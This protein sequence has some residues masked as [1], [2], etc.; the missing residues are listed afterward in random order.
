MQVIGCDW[1]SANWQPCWSGCFRMRKLGWQH[2]AV[3]TVLRGWG[4]CSRIWNSSRDYFRISGPSITKTLCPFE[5]YGS[6]YPVTRRRTSQKSEAIDIALGLMPL[7]L[8]T[9]GHCVVGTIVFYC[10]SRHCVVDKTQFYCT[11][12]H[13]VVDTTVFYVLQ[14][15]VLS[16]QQNFILLQGIVF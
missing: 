8:K 2:C 10:T 15:I 4:F 3:L 6:D 5:T 16:A 14:R 7:L 12:R 11:S 1:G 13:C 9:L